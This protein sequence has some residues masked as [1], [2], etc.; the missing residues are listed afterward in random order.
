M[1]RLFGEQ[2]AILRLIFSPKKYFC[3]IDK[4]F[5]HEK[6]TLNEVA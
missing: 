2:M 1:E 5:N 3:S 6:K 4:T